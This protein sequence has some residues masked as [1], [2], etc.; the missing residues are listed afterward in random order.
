MKYEII[1]PSDKATM[2]TGNFMAAAVA[3][4]LIGHGKYPLKPLEPG[5]IEVP[6]FVFGGHEEWFTAQF[7][8]G[9]TETI[10]HLMEHDVDAL[11]S[12]LESVQLAGRRTSL[13]DIVG[14][15]LSM[16]KSLRED[17]A[18]KAATPDQ[19]P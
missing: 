7:G 11:A 18:A 5:G 12:A 6:M 14:G 4:V 17:A 15:A 16:A 2:E 10:N 8:K 19:T 9:L 3:A 1:N 13:N